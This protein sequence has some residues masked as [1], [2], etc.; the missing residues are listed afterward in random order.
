MASV[1]VAVVVAIVAATA[2]VVVHFQPV[3]LGQE[4]FAG[5][6]LAR[7]LTGRLPILTEVP[8]HVGVHSTLTQCG[9]W[10][11]EA[12][13]VALQ[14]QS[15]VQVL[16]GVRVTAMAVVVKVVAVVV[17]VVAVVVVVVMV[18]VIIMISE[19]DRR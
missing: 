17:K 16:L 7:L 9:L 4:P 15:R 8:V 10:E 1:G 3:A 5:V 18:A 19:D 2:M 6:G 14:F 12:A 13:L 11:A